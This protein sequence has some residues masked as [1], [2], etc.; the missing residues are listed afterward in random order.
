MQSLFACS[1][2]P[3]QILPHSYRP[4]KAAGYFTFLYRSFAG[5]VAVD[6]NPHGSG[7]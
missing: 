7:E 5:K 2:T 3:R 4:S 1:E 6:A